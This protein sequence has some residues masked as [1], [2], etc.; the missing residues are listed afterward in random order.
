MSNLRTARRTLL[1]IQLRP[2]TPEI[3]ARYS[4]A[5]RKRITLGSLMKG[6]TIKETR[7]P[8]GMPEQSKSET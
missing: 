7:V 8:Y 5:E 3:K 6:V 2:V 1:K 4:K